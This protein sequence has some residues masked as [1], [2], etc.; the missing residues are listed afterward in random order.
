M[1]EAVPSLKFR[2]KNAVKILNGVMHKDNFGA[3]LNH[4]DAKKIETECVCV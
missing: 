2:A 3:T 1:T 4:S